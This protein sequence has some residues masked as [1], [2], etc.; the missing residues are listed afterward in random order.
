M[1]NL[2]A[3]QNLMGKWV[4]TG[5]GWNLIAVPTTP[6]DATSPVAPGTSENAI[7]RRVFHPGSPA[8]ERNNQYFRDHTLRL[9][10]GTL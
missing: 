3:I 9:P 4:G 1:S 10:E 5:N 2:G 8:S 7:R 6:P